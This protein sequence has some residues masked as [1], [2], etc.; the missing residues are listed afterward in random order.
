MKK[1]K[2]KFVNTQK[3][4]KKGG[5]QTLKRHG[6][7]HFS[8]IA[9]KRWAKTAKERAQ[10]KLVLAKAGSEKEKSARKP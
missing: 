2:P 9:K 10:K 4:G 1:K 6:R 8:D 3:I 7:K 5:A